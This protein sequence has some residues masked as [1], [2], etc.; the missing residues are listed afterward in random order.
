MNNDMS[1]S[2]SDVTY[3]KS[4]F[5]PALFISLLIGC[6]LYILYAIVP[7]VY[8]VLGI[9]VSASLVCGAI[10]PDITYWLF[11]VTLMWEVNQLKVAYENHIPVAYFPYMIFLLATL[12]GYLVQK[13]NRSAKTRPAQPLDSFVLLLFFFELVG[14]LWAVNPVYSLF[15]HIFLFFNLLIYFFT[16]YFVSSVQRLGQMLHVLFATGIL[17][18]VCMILNF[19]IDKQYSIEICKYTQIEYG[20]SSVVN[21][22]SGYASAQ[23]GSGFL[24]LLLF[25][26]LPVITNE[27][28]R[29]RQYLYV[30]I[31]LLFLVALMLSL[32]RGSLLGLIAIVPF[33]IVL[34]PRFRNKRFL[35]ITICY[36]IIFATMIT[37]KPTYIDRIMLTLGYTGEMTGSNRFFRTS[38]IDVSKGQGV[39]GWDTRMYRFNRALE[40]MSTRPVTF[41]TGLGAGGF[42]A[43][44]KFD[45]EVT[46]LLL[47]LFFDL[48]LI[49]IFLLYLLLYSLARS[50]ISAYH[51]GPFTQS[52]R[53][54]LASFCGL[55]ADG[56]VHGQ[57]DYDW[58]ALGSK[59]IFFYMGFYMACR[60]VAISADVDGVAH[61]LSQRTTVMSSRVLK[62]KKSA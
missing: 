51:S 37:A 36:G 44:Q 24:V 17:I 58:N 7:P 59:L 23:H 62:N 40:Y 35:S 57:F 39:T 25:L 14:T 15:W 38:N 11:V 43:V 55:L 2:V 47:A 13:V 45:P 32:A 12:G 61:S 18:S 60:H 50:F 49:G 30:G 20:F 5:R 28:N 33:Y 16:T 42:T 19:W 3:L 1:G 22:L 8:F 26:L 31:A 56:F 9:L 52:H 4:K 41:L 10:R 48:G 21:R 34:D 29:K 6:G 46:N 27:K 53:I 54:M